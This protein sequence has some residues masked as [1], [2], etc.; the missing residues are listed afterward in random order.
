MRFPLTNSEQFSRIAFSNL[1]SKPDPI[2]EMG[3]SMEM[4]LQN[5]FYMVRQP[6]VQQKRHLV[7]LTLHVV[8][9]DIHTESCSLGEMYYS[10]EG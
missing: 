10:V 3:K 5:P 6:N 1:K 9:K 2:R 4:R 7:D 8:N